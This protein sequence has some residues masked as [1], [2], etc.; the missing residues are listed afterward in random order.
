MASINVNWND[1]RKLYADDPAKLAEDAGAQGKL[2]LQKYLPPPLLSFIIDVGHRIWSGLPFSKGLCY[3][4]GKNMDFSNYVDPAKHKA[5]SFFKCN[6]LLKWLLG[7]TYNSGEP[8][9]EYKIDGTPMGDNYNLEFTEAKL[10]FDFCKVYI[11]N[12]RFCKQGTAN[13]LRSSRGINVNNDVWTHINA[14]VSAVD[15]LNLINVTSFGDLTI[16]GNILQNSTLKCKFDTTLG[17]N[18]TLKNLFGK[19]RRL[20]CAV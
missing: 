12:I 3:F 14:F 13:T 16:K 11:N 4:P 19:L 9:T 10:M 6:V 7:E 5:S 15:V 17:S 18:R 2:K 1:I 20:K 8:G